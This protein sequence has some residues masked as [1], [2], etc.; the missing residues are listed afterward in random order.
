M[1]D[2]VSFDHPE[3]LNMLLPA[4]VHLLLALAEL[5]SAVACYLFW[6]ILP[7]DRQA[8]RIVCLTKQL[9]SCRE[10]QVRPRRFT[11]GARLTLVWLTRRFNVWEDAGVQPA[12]LRRW[13]RHAFR[14][15]WRW[16]SRP[17]GRPP[18]R[19]DLRELIER[20]VK[21]NHGIGQ[22]AVAGVLLLRFGLKVSPRTV[23][24]YWPGPPRP[25]GQPLAV[26]EVWKTFIKNQV[27]ATDFFVAV[28]ATFRL[29]YVFLAIELNSRRI[30]HCNVTAHP[31]AEWTLQ[32]FREIFSDDSPYR[33]LIHDRDSI[34]S[35]E[36]DEAVEA[37]GVKVWRT[38][39]HQPLANARCE[40]L[41]GT[42]RRELLDWIIPWGEGHLRRTVKIW[43][44]YYNHHRPHRG[45]HPDGV[46]RIPEPIEPPPPPAINRHQI[47]A[48]YE[49]EAR[50]I[51]GGLRHVYRLKKAA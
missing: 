12:T 38:P 15:L 50:P 8:A 37:V 1:C 9:A 11:D 18:L 39:P 2:A 33:A 21:E 4:L 42:L 43:A 49:I 10:R 22:R 6:C 25:T 5:L 28:T 30:V 48:G 23:R 16:K 44:D 46:P 13:H 20:I 3:I 17:R 7:K 36:V 35:K 47:A 29:L 34:Y 24:K 45:K 31:T 40:R 51:L 41:G 19:K 27:V 26:S 32:Q 14:L